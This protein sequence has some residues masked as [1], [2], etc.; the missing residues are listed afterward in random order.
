MTINY[1]IGKEDLFICHK[2]TLRKKYF[3]F[4]PYVLI[5]PLFVA[6]LYMFDK[7]SKIIIDTHFII[8]WIIN[9]LLLIGVVYLIRNGIENG[10]KK[11][12]RLNPGITG[13]R[14]FTVYADKIIVSSENSL[15]EYKITAIKS[16]EEVKDFYL[17]DTFHLR[18]IVIPQNVEGV[19]QLIKKLKDILKI[20]V[21]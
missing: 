16:V 18:T 2:R 7:N 13:Q 14:E 20:N 5:I 10:I 3:F 4:K 12:I 15:T 9:V 6:T 11:S 8:Q 21:C 19:E 17:I 1:H